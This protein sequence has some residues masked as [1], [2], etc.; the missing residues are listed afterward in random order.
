MNGVELDSVALE[1]PEKFSRGEEDWD[2]EETLFETNKRPFDPIFKL[3]EQ[4]DLP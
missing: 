3:H 1:F 2:A 4:G